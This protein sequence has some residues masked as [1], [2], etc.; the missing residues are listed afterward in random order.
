MLY[1]LGA[2]SII[3]EVLGQLR[4][5]LYKIDNWLFKKSLKLAFMFSHLFLFM[6]AVRI[7]LFIFLFHIHNWLYIF[8]CLFLF[9]RYITFC[10]F[11]DKY[12][13]CI[14]NS[15]LFNFL[16]WVLWF[17]GKKNVFL[18]NLYLIKEVEPR[19]KGS[20]YGQDLGSCLS[21]LFSACSFHCDVPKW[22]L[23]LWPS[24]LHSCH[25]E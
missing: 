10:K 6:S 3:R 24:C 14:W 11:S 12:R 5:E 22:L 15:K 8:I 17:L 18:L 20:V 21:L 25:L 4:V 23:Q 1:I 2:D 13:K 16:I 19:V 9:L 7:L